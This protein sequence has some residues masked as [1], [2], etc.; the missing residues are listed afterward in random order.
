MRE[1]NKERVCT[2]KVVF[3]LAKDHL[4]SKLVVKGN[5]Q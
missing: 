4:L 2:G 3:M 5:L 1:C